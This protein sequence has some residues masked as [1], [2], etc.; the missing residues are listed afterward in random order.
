MFHRQIPSIFAGISVL[1]LFLTQAIHADTLLS[2]EIAK[3]LQVPIQRPVVRKEKKIPLKKFNTQIT[4]GGQ[5]IPIKVFGEKPQANFDLGENFIFYYIDGDDVYYTS[6]QHILDVGVGER[7]DIPSEVAVC[8]EQQDWFT[9]ELKINP[10]SCLY[11]SIQIAADYELSYFPHLFKNITSTELARRFLL[12]IEEKLVATKK[13]VTAVSFSPKGQS[14]L[15]C[16]FSQYTEL[17]TALK[18][19]PSLVRGG[20][21]NPK[22]LGLENIVVFLQLL[23][24]NDQGSLINSALTDVNSTLKPRM[25]FDEYRQLNISTLYNS[26]TKECS[27][28][29]ADQ[30]IN[31]IQGWVNRFPPQQAVELQPS[32]LELME[33]IQKAFQGLVSTPVTTTTRP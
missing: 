10:A 26:D 19:M 4:L 32:D 25:K 5:I 17:G 27:V 28:K 1:C 33:R 29:T 13:V 21:L 2:D 18:T 30:I 16:I 14:P 7:G 12:N 9:T 3:G 8:K 11:R 23:D 24:K 31:V 15:D 6:V 20:L 22:V